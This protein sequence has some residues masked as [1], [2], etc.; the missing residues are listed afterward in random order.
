VPDIETTEPVSADN[1]EAFSEA[2]LEPGDGYTVKVDGAESQVSLQEL[3][4]GYQRQAD[5]TRKT[6]EL[7]SERQRLQQAET[8]VSA[9]EADPAGTLT[10][11]HNAFG[12]TDNVPPQQDNWS[13]GESWDTEDAD[14]TTQRIANLEAQL[15]GQAR[16]QRQ[17]ALEK[18]VDS[19][20]DKYGDFDS[21][22]LYN[23][24]LKNRIPNLEAAYTH[25]RFSEVAAQAEK[26]QSDRDVTD[27]KRDA[28]VVETGGSAQAG[29]VV[30]ANEAGKKPQSLREAFALAKQQVGT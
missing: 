26:L 11:L 12:V 23:H 14:P 29:S 19:L 9:L 5:Y 4:D 27:A 15:A 30:S 20:K 6:Q 3:Q 10:A 22:E 8:I 17:Q 1:P 28:N 25:M 7:A 2:T 21:Q 24:A 16:A 13:S 18:E